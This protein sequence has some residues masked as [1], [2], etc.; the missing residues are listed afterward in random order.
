MTT[1]F[2][3]DIV[4]TAGVG[5]TAC[6]PQLPWESCLFVTCTLRIKA[7]L[8]QI[9]LP[10]CNLIQDLNSAVCICCAPVAERTVGPEIGEQSSGGTGSKTPAHSSRIDDNFLLCPLLTLDSQVLNAWPCSC[11]SGMS[12]GSFFFCQQIAFQSLPCEGR[13]GKVYDFGSEA[14]IIS[15]ILFLKAIIP[16]M[17]WITKC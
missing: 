7:P 5:R 12:G 3:K 6:L 8:L 14:L 11:G 4:P 10:F 17:V 9:S 13:Y 16:R 15:H 1:R 2:S